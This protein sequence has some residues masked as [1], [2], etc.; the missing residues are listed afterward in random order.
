MLEYAPKHIKGDYKIALAAVQRD[1]W[2]LEAVS[3]ELQANRDIVIAAVAQCGVAPSR[4][5][6]CV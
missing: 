5:A 3:K 1:G 2:N 6:P 4:A